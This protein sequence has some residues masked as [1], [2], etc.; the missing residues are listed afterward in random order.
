MYLALYAR[1]AWVIFDHPYNGDSA[2]PTLP[3]TTG[4]ARMARADPSLPR[5]WESRNTEPY[6]LRPGAASL[7]RHMTA[8]PGRAS[9]R[10]GAREPEQDKSQ[11]VTPEPIKP[12]STR[13]PLAALA[14]RI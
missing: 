3:S 13:G 4:T 8:S 14:V 12:G 10:A 2:T 7:A 9:D 1:R 6:P 11:K 5:R